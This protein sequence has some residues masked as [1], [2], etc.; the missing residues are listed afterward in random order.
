MLTINDNI[1]GSQYT[2]NE[3]DIIILDESLRFYGYQGIDDLNSIINK[4]KIMHDENNFYYKVTMI[5]FLSII[6]IGTIAITLSLIYI[7]KQ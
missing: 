3:K 6:L 4:N 7:N 1:N 5:A 2:M